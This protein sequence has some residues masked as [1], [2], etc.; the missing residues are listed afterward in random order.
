MQSLIYKAI[1]NNISFAFMGEIA[2]KLS[3]LV[4]YWAV[5]KFLSPQD[6]GV[7][8]TF[9][10]I[11]AGC[12]LIWEGGFSKA[13]IKLE[14][15][16]GLVA[17]NAF[18]L[19]QALALILGFWLLISP[20]F[21]S[22]FFLGSANFTFEMQLAAVYVVLSSLASIPICLLQKEAKF[23][24]IAVIRLS[25]ATV[26]ILVTV[27]LVI[28]FDLKHLALI[29]GLLTAQ[30]IQ[31]LMLAKMSKWRPRL[32]LS[33]SISLKLFRFAKWVLISSFAAWIFAW[34]DSIFVVRLL[35]IEDLGLFRMASHLVLMA[36]FLVFSPITPLIYSRLVKFENYSDGSLVQFLTVISFGAGLFITVSFSVLAPLV[37]NLVNSD[38]WMELSSLIVLASLTQVVPY[39]YMFMGEFYRAAGMPKIEALQRLGSVL[40]LF[41]FFILCSAT[42]LETFM[43]QRLIL[44]FITGFLELTCIFFL[45]RNIPIYTLI[46]LMVAIIFITLHVFYDVQIFIFF[47]PILVIA[48]IIIKNIRKLEFLLN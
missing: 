43:E 32:V 1:Y 44:T 31:L 39:I 18:I 20:D 28:L 33:K 24:K 26:P 46:G 47:I 25:V 15:G 7:Y 36:Y 2:A 16:K 22:G 40:A 11:V 27:P 21:F 37:I 13:V 3:P 23:G 48:I 19:N 4:T 5:A 41:T 8:S 6:F 12:A 38:A 30:L 29:Y 14:D 42:T 9:L 35:T 10:I 17:S 45:L 34:G